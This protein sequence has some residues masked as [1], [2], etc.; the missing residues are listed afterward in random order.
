MWAFRITD[1]KEVPGW[2]RSESLRSFSQAR[3]QPGTPGGKSFL[4]GAQIF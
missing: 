3:S 4:R 2:L 1:L